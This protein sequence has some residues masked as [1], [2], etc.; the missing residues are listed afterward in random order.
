VERNSSVFVST[1]PVYATCFIHLSMGE[2]KC[3]VPKER[4]EPTPLLAAPSIARP[5]VALGAICNTY[6]DLSRDGK[7][8]RPI[9]RL[10]LRCDLQPW[11]QHQQYPSPHCHLPR[12]RNTW[13][14]I[15]SFL[16]SN[17]PCP[18]SPSTAFAQSTF[19]L[20]YPLTSEISL[21]SLASQP[22]LHT[23]LAQHA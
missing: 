1:I 8:I 15:P 6:F 16:P 13:H 7:F 19:F 18:L 23:I 22:V 5:R 9:G 3:K 14:Q 20:I 21:A 12:T 10:T 4:R 17:N 2:C 11:R